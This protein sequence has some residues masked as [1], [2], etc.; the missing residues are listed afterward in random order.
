[1]NTNTLIVV[2]IIIVIIAGFFLFQ[3]SDTTTPTVSPTSITDDTSMAQPLTFALAAQSN[4]GQSGTATISDNNGKAQVTITLFAAT[5]STTSQP[6]HIHTGSCPTPGGV[7]Y[8]LAA[9]SNGSSQTM[10]EVSVSQLLSELPLAINVHASETQINTYV[11]CGDI[12]AG[13]AG[14]TEDL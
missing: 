12:P 5:E 6:A 4:S 9:V 13:T 11:A 2:I 1:M 14:S 10:L 7:T 3:N 8:P